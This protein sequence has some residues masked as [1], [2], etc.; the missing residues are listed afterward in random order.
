MMASCYRE[1][2]V[3]ASKLIEILS[4]LP[5]GCDP[6]IVTGEEWLPERLL[7]VSFQDDYV[8]CHFDTAP[9]DQQGDDEGRGFVDHEIEL[10]NAHIMKIFL[11][12]APLEQKQKAIL[13]LILYAHEHFPSD[14]VE[15][16]ESTEPTNPSEKRS[17]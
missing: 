10:I 6:D 1:Q 4:T 5:Q 13:Q 7:D 14:V 17:I 9:E 11:K 12:K 8:F 16:L 2:T 3:K 15:I